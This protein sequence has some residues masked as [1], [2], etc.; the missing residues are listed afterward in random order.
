MIYRVQIFKDDAMKTDCTFDTRAELAEYLDVLF[1]AY[2][3]SEGYDYTVSAEQTTR[4]TLVDSEV[5]TDGS[6]TAD[7]LWDFICGHKTQRS[8]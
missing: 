3:K 7:K 2:P 6:S 4:Y 5:L 1:R 8:R